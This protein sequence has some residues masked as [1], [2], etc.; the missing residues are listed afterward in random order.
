MRGSGDCF[1]GEPLTAYTHGHTVIRHINHHSMT[2]MRL[3]IAVLKKFLTCRHCT[4]ATLITGG[5]TFR[6]QAFKGKL[7]PEGHA[8]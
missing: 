7:V 4:G 2:C 5:Y 3:D 6:I 8:G 1:G